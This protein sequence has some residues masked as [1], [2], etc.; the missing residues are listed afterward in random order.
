[1]GKPYSDDLRERV[2]ATIEAGH[3]REE[4]AELYNRPLSTVGRFIRRKRETGSVSP[5][6]F[7][8]HKTYALAPHTDLV[9][10]LVAEQPD[11]TLAELEARLTKQKVKVSKSAI[12]RFLHHLNL[13]FKKKS[14]H[15]A[16]QDREDVAA[17]RKALRKAQPTLD[18]KRLVFIDE[19][20]TTTKMTRLYGRAPQGERLVEKVPHGHWKTTTFICGLRYNG[21]TAPFALDGAMDGPHFLAYIEQILAPTLKKG[22]IVFMDNVSTHLVDGAEEAIEARGA[23]VHYL[24]AY[25]P[26]F[27]PIEQLFSKLKAFL[28]KMKAR[29]VEALWKMIASFLKEVTKEGCKA[30]L[31]NSGYA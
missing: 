3:T 12:S 2:V 16:E 11:S 17:A 4:V 27:N 14:I 15:A 23:S 6:K 18:P 24:P 19:A 8:G 29:T 9:S 7:G 30:F 20:A 22:D 5:D 1:M 26:D 25:S 13:T 21:V 10:A 31:A 28:R